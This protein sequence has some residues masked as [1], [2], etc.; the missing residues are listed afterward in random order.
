MTKRGMQLA[1]MRVAGYHDDRKAFTRLL[2][3]TRINRAEADAA[4]ARG[5]EQRASGMGCTCFHCKQAQ[6]F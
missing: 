1:N 3:E 4:F 2:I 5:Q 6:A